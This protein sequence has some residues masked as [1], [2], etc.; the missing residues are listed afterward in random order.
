MSYAFTE[1]HKETISLAKEKRGKIG[2]RFFLS[3][4]LTMMLL[5]ACT[6]RTNEITIVEGKE[7]TV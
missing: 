3:C 6:I 1:K 7:G 4:F 2:I 5:N